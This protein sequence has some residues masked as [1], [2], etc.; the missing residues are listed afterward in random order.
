MQLASFR[1]TGHQS[2]DCPRD[3]V[4]DSAAS[5]SVGK[6]GSAGFVPRR[7]QSRSLNCSPS[8]S[9]SSYP[10]TTPCLEPP[11]SSPRSFPLTEPQ[12]RLHVTP[13]A[14]AARLSYLPCSSCLQ[15]GS[16]SCFGLKSTSCS[17]PVPTPSA[18]L[19]LSRAC[20]RP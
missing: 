19:S 14:L 2:R 13:Q 20:A 1:R 10:P 4:C 18:P 3:G 7:V 11:F 9:N 15:T 5:Q 12:A 17:C 8:L 16:R 6:V